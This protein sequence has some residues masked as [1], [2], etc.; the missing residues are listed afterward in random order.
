MP[1]KISIDELMAKMAD[2][3]TDQS[4]LS[5]YFL[6]DEDASRPFA[7]QFTLN[8]QTVS[9][10]K[11][12]DAAARSA[13]AMN[14]ANWF[15]RMHRQGQFYK[16]LRNGYQG[17]IIVSEGD[18]WFQY[19]ILL[20]DTIDHLSDDYAIF[21]LGA[22]GDLLQNMADKNEF[23]GAIRDKGAEILLLSGGGNDLVAGGAL[24][25]HLEEFDANLQPADYLLP[26]FQALLDNALVQ[27]TRMF[28][29][30]RRDTPHVKVLCHGY[31]YPVPNKDRW[32][33]KPME[34][35]GIKDRALQKAIAACMMDQFNRR[36][37]RACKAMPHVS[38]IDCRGV[39]GDHRW[40]DGLHPTNE[41]YASVAQLFAREIAKI[42]N[43]R[44]GPPI[45]RSGPFGNADELRQTIEA[46]AKVSSP[47]SLGKGR[48]LHI[49][50]DSVD[51]AHY[52]GWDG[53]L[54]SCEAD[55]KAMERLAKDNGFASKSLLT[56]AAT[57]AKVISEIKAAA[58]ELEAGSMFL[59]TVSGHGG[60]IPDFN[61]DEDHDGDE[62]MDETLCLFDFQLADD[63]LYMLWG[64]FRAGVR[65][66]MVADTCHSGS[67]VRAGPAMPTSLF[68]QPIEPKD[69]GAVRAMPLAVEERVWMQNRDAYRDASRSYS[70]IKESVMMAPLTSPV[71]ASVL[72]LGAC[73]DS[74]F[75]TDGPDH[76]AFT[77][78][79][80]EIWN[81]GQFVG[82]YRA[83]R[84][85]IDARIGRGTQT[86]QLFEKLH[87]APNFI[88]DI[89]FSINPDKKARSVSPAYAVAAVSREEAN[90]GHETD[91]LSDE[92][93]RAIFEAKRGHVR[94]RS[95]DAALN[96]SEYSDF[97]AFIK[98]LGLQHF[99][100][101]EFLVLGGAHS[102]PGGNCAGLNTYPPRALWPN[103]AATARALDA[104]RV[105]LGQ[106]IAIT[107]AYRAPAYNTCIDGASSSLHMQFNALDFKVRA[108][109]APAVAM[110]LRWLRDKDG[111]FVGG[112]GRY[113]SFTHIDTRGNNA[114]WFA[115]FKAAQ[116]PD[117]FPMPPVV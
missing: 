89:P 88:G 36:L 56:S 67:M 16:R 13:A 105:K 116:V 74:Q 76:G 63:E 35:R 117:A 60:R 58:R 61:Q 9:I 11:G 79:L 37:R 109:S 101:D 83:F 112:I 42:A 104:V 33:G 71:K 22:A 86:P 95:G 65:V 91:S 39:V 80:L 75:A 2:L 69:Q 17:P 99:G 100:T 31:D 14:G 44:S 66:L 77:G 102:T 114:T 53:K 23:I 55:A 51:P 34:S 25:L 82:D 73:K 48:S 28:E 43:T 20:R 57:R 70:A 12:A 15:A 115:D 64:E 106:P 30:V 94:M 81:D 40:H 62:K 41:G 113:N 3:D 7:P 111:L 21:S 68:G 92:D 29:L 72:S 90:E 1:K 98:S 50:L 18:S 103:I 96:W 110:A 52:A 97:D 32:L 19:P 38:Y 84:A 45:A 8:P 93:V 27:Y 108:M 24:A 59:L 49:G 85:A 6:I 107:N 47:T 78:A 26:S 87:R 46:N 4:D 54:Q 5:Q 10:P